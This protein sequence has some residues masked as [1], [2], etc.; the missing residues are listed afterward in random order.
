MGSFNVQCALTGMTFGYQDPIYVMKL[1]LNE[2]RPKSIELNTYK[3]DD[4]FKIYSFPE[5][6]TYNDYGKFE[7]ITDLCEANKILKTYG[8]IDINESVIWM[9]IHKKAYEFI[10]SKFLSKSFAS[11]AILIYEQGEQYFRNINSEII[12]KCKTGAFDRSYDEN[13]QSLKSAWPYGIPPFINTVLSDYIYSKNDVS[14]LDDTTSRK[15][16]ELYLLYSNFYTLRKLFA[17]SNYAGQQ[18]NYDSYRK[19]AEVVVEI[20]KDK[21]EMIDAENYG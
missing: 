9:G 14:F 10:T 15:L 5:L 1:L 8:E 13:Y 21:Q 4:Y 19:L 3:P 12:F 2:S 20:A 6:T 16:Y 17:R 7:K 11:N 18:D